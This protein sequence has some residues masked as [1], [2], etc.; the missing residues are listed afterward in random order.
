MKH[1]I[2]FSKFKGLNS[3]VELDDISIIISNFVKQN[4]N[5]KVCNVHPKGNALVGTLKILM[6]LITVRLRSNQWR[7]NYEIRSTNF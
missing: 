6:I 2:T 5:L 7:S 3:I 4:S 1:K